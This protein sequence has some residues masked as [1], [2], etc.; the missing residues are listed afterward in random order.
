[1]MFKDCY[2]P[3]PLIPTIGIIVDGPNSNKN[4]HDTVLALFIE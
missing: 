4:T 3:F 1:M 2:G